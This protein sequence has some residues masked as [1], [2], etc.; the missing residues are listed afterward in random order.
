MAKPLY[1]S[2]AAGV[3]IVLNWFPELR[4]TLAK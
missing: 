3:A 2:A 4:A 1:P